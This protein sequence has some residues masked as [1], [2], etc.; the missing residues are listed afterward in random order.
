MI[1]QLVA[2]VEAVLASVAQPGDVEELQEL[3]GGVQLAGKVSLV[4]VQPEHL[5]RGED[6]GEVDLPPVLF[7]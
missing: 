1:G 4:Q 3:F 6:L 7:S 2:A 5:F